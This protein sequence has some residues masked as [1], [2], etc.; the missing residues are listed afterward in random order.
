MKS[1]MRICVIQLTRIGDVIQT[2]Q[3][4]K[5]L[6]IENPNIELTLIARKQFSQGLN[7]LLK[8]VFSNIIELNTQDFFQS[9][10]DDLNA[11]HTRL[12]NFVHDIKKFDF[13]LVVNL[14]FTKSSSFLT[15]LISKNLK[16]GVYRNSQGEIGINDK[17]SQFVYSNVMGGTSTPINLVDIYKNMLG[18]KEIDVTNFETPKNKVIT[19]HPFASSSKKSWGMGKWNELIY[20]LLKDDSE[21]TINMVGAPTDKEQAQRI[22]SNPAI[23]HFEGRVLNKVG[24]N[25]IEDTFNDLSSSHMFIGHDSMVSHLAG[26][27]RMPSLIISLGSVRPHETN[28]YN[29]NTYNLTPR[30]KCFPC[31]IEEKCDLLPCHGSINHQTVVAVTQKMLAGEEVSR[32]SLMENLTGFHLDT[33]NILKSSFDEAGIKLDEI[34][35][36]NMSAKEVFRTFY[37]ILWS[38]YLTGKE[39]GAD[40]PKV[41]PDVSKVLATHL[42]GSNYLFEL[43]NYGFTFSNKILDEAEREDPSIKNIQAGVDKLTEIDYLC[44][45][46][47]KTYSHLEPIIDFFYVNKANALGSNIIEIT[48]N[49]LISFHEAT[50]LTAILNDLIIKTVGPRVEPTAQPRQEV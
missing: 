39:V 36:N 38:Y 42:D 15:T 23:Q 18:A 8:D 31:K 3:A 47:K 19:I 29:D 34:T 49:N 32:K 9:S 11:V 20:K 43:Y 14:S 37:R 48:N 50:N 24:L 44:N 27:F 5:Q 40:L 10:K 28:P 4:A 12:H 2:Y 7:F 41:S 1:S 16:M 25:S 46:T 33:V 17:W 30:N 35:E 21:I 45:I 13:D 26:I 6:K 22:M